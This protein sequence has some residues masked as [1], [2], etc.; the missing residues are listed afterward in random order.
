MVAKAKEKDCMTRRARKLEQRR[1]LA[2]RLPETARPVMRTESGRRLSA[3][4][5][6]V[7]EFEAMLERHSSLPNGAR[8]KI[9]KKFFGLAREGYSGG[10]EKIAPFAMRLYSRQT[11]APKMGFLV[12]AGDFKK[13]DRVLSL[14]CGA[15]IHEAFIAKRLAPKGKVIGIDLSGRLVN[16]ARRIAQLENIGNA[17]FVQRSALRTGLSAGRF[18]KIVCNWLLNIVRGKERISTILEIKRLI[19]KSP[20]SRVLITMPNSDRGSIGE[21]VQLLR[22]EDFQVRTVGGPKQTGVSFTGIIAIPASA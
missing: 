12:L 19:K 22:A 6:K 9:A 10:I 21:V 1:L 13:E 3:S 4:T 17:D 14:G 7:G 18:D 2:A 20:E 8:K 11:E 15:G 16:T 5:A